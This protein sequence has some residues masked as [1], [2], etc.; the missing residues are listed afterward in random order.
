[1]VPIPSDDPSP[2]VLPDATPARIR[3][4]WF[5]LAILFSMNLLNYIDRYVFASVGP[6]VQKEL[7]LTDVQ[8]GTLASAFMVVYTLI[9]PAVGWM[10][11]RYERRR[12]LAFGVGL[13]SVATVGTAFARDF[14]QMFF[15]RALLGVGEASYGVV[16]PALL[17]DLFPVRLRGRVMG[18]FYL[19]L[20]LGAALGYGLGGW[21]EL[22]LGWRMAF[23]VVGLPGLALAAAGLLIR[24][25]GRGASE[26]IH[27]TR[28]RLRDYKVLLTTPSFTFNILGMAAV[29]FTT[30]AFGHWGPTFYNRVRHMP[31]SRANF[32]L[33]TLTAVAGLLGILLGTMI[34]ENMRK[35]TRRAYL[36]WA[37]VAVILAIPF[38]LIG[39]LDHDR[40]TSM[41]LLFLA[42]VLMA[43]V[44]G[45][46]NTVPA[47]V[48]PPNLRAT[49]YAINILF[50]HLL[51]DISSP[52]LIGTLSEYFGSKEVIL[53]PLGQTIEMIGAA[54]QRT[55]HTNLTAG[56]LAV[57]P[58]LFLGAI[59][60][61]IG[62]HYLARDED[63]AHRGKPG[64]A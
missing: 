64:H 15:W 29:T 33:G 59:F 31:L 41:S 54:P 14:N 8:F 63:R 39:I 6:A 4:A 13:W 16:A 55:T 9:S 56:M 62:S 38:G 24:D 49:A 25:P 35:V 20:P 10:G 23:G 1:M 11:D 32:Y 53:S 45:P 22:H 52:I 42:M 7:S 40:R 12:L 27:V 47:N 50:I 57:V 19:A 43:S 30:G 5:A 34:A 46:C 3:G 58:V 51:G 37:A 60:F 2:S 36:L 48:V 28:P 44:L 26:G 17:A 21:I 61:L 18:I